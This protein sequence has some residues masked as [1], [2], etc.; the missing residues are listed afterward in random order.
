MLTLGQKQDCLPTIYIVVLLI[1]IIK[2]NRKRTT[3]L[4]G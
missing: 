1:I 2:K 3:I 4:A